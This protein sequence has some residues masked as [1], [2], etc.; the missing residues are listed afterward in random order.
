MLVWT[1]TIPHSVHQDCKGPHTAIK[2]S[3]WMCVCA[4]PGH[5][6]C[7]H[8]HH[9]AASNNHPPPPTIRRRPPAV[10][11]LSS[12]HRCSFTTVADPGASG[13]NLKLVSCFTTAKTKVKVWLG[14]QVIRYPGALSP[15]PMRGGDRPG[16]A[17]WQK[18]RRRKGRC[19]DCLQQ[20][21]SLLQ[22]PLSRTQ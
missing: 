1:S 19:S 5:C 2:T 9:E 8:R 15:P 13:A 18:D 6:T 17:G 12:S 22:L 11:L 7:A 14:P 21:K 3:I 4:L 10:P 16:E 20:I